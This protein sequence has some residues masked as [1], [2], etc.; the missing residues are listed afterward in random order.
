MSQRLSPDRRSFK[1]SLSA[2]FQQIQLP[3]LRGSADDRIDPQFL[4]D[5][6]QIRQ[7]VKAGKFDLNTV[8]NRLTKLT[9]RIVGA[10]GVGVWLFT[11]D[12]VFLYAGAGS[13]S[14]DERL[15]LEVISKLASAC[16]LSQDSSSRSANRTKIATSYHASDPDDNNSLLVELVH[17]GQNVAGA[18]AALSDECNAFTQ[19]DV[20]NLHLLADLL[21]QTLSKA[22]EAGLQESVTLEPAAMLQLIERII[23]A[24]ERMVENDENARH[25]T[26]GFIRGEPGHEFPSA[27]I[28][29]KR[30]QD[31][32]PTDRD[33]G[34]RREIGSTRTGD[35]QE[36]SVLPDSAPSSPLPEMS[37]PRIGM[38]AAWK[39]KTS[40]LQPI[41]RHG[42]ERAA[43]LVRNRAPLKLNWTRVSV[44]AL[45]VQRGLLYARASFLH[46][47]EVT[48]TRLRVLLESR[49]S[50]RSSLMAVPVAAMVIV[51]AFLALRLHFHSS[52]QATAP[53]PRTTAIEKPIP[54]SSATSDAQEGLVLDP[55]KTTS[56]LQV[57]HMHVTDRATEDA[58]RTLSRYE[59]A[60]LRRRA[61]YGDDSAVF[62]M[63]M[64]SEIGRGLPQSCTTAAQWVARAAGEG[65]PAAQYNLGLRYRDGDGVPVNEDESVR[66]LRKAAGQ[67]SPDAKVALEVLTAQ[68]ARVISSAQASH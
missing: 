65:N 33:A 14:N 43:A 1:Q 32:Q 9:Q 47:I 12:E 6:I 59:L 17:Q 58:V 3:G 64:A 53:G 48:K 50:L 23:P 7:E 66:W 36:A 40:T 49:S 45:V 41:V 46:A 15:R 4:L 44:P 55:V 18:L 10:C 37:G 51:V 13:A 57:S 16:Q 42:W 52:H 60:G 34:V 61:E 8:I 68:Q 39:N 54:L 25:L 21:G 27:G 20:A 35:N 22:A 38:W 2:L 11:S 67:H 29:T 28:P 5:L 26:H 24:L 63:G 62:Q 31:S 56:P 30:F 19:R